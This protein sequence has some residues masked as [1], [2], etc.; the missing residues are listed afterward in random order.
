[1]RER[2][3]LKTHH[4]AITEITREVIAEVCYVSFSDLEPII[5][6]W[7][8]H[9]YMVWNGEIGESPYYL[10]RW[11]ADDSVSVTIDEVIDKM[12]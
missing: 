10:S 1:M 11:P 2:I 3:I 7:G 8:N 9:L 6:Q 5:D 12:F 4:I